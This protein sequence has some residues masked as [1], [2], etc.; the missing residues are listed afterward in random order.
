MTAPHDEACDQ[1]PCT[2]DKMTDPE[3]DF[4]IIEPE[5]ENTAISFGL[6]LDGHSFDRGARTPVVSFAEQV[7]Y[8]AIVDPAALERVLERLRRP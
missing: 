4:L 5:W 6:A 7:R 8:L 3:A 1:D 2:C